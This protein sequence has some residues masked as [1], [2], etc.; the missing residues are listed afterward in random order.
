MKKRRLAIIFAIMMIFVIIFL[1]SSPLFKLNSVEAVF[2]DEDFNR[3]STANNAVFT[4]KESI[5]S[6]ISK[7]EFNYG[8]LIFF[9]SKDR[10]LKRIENTSPYVKVLSIE[11]VFPSK[12][13]LNL[14]ERVEKLYIS[15]FESNF[16][17]DSEFKILREERIVPSSLLPIYFEN[18]F[19]SRETFFDFF[20]ISPLAFSEG[21]FLSENNYVFSAIMRMFPAINAV[22]IG[23]V[24]FLS[25]FLMKKDSNNVVSLYIYSTSP[26]GA[27]VC[28]EDVVKDFDYKLSKVLSA[29]T[30]LYFR[31][32]IKTTHGTLKIDKSK[33]VSWSQNS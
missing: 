7:A 8:E 31:E 21:Q 2:F 6:V 28:I 30:T 9:S 17:L 24:S 27:I 20:D 26:F 13:R 14:Q 4:S 22:D 25:S 29:L 10:Y 11:S 23:Y 1:L 3:K 5:D 18:E 15:D 16:V 32:N 19:S 12:L 33:N